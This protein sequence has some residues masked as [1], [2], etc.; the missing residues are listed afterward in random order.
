MNVQSTTI[1]ELRTHGQ[2]QE[3]RYIEQITILENKT[4]EMELELQYYVDHPIFNSTLK[5]SNE[6]HSLS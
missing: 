2:Q 6:T 4:T 1:Q 3:A 5:G